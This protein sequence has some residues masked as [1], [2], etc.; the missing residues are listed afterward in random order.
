M[1]EQIMHLFPDREFFLL[2]DNTQLDLRIYLRIAEKFPKNIR[3]II[4]RKVL[5]GVHDEAYLL[6]ISE[7]LKRKGIGF[8]YADSFP[9][10]FDLWDEL[11]Q[12]IHIE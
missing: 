6:E 8:Y 3:Y 7:K 4:I 2:G 11:G 9:S 10:K 5:S 12:K 1:L